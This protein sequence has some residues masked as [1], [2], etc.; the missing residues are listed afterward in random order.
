MINGKHSGSPESGRRRVM[1]P[2]AMV[3]SVCLMAL[4][5][6]A[7]AACGGSSSASG[8]AS[9]SSA[10][11]TAAGGATGAGRFTALRSC[12]EKQGIKLPAPRAGRPPSGGFGAG[13]RYGRP[14]GGFHPPAGSSRTKLAEAI[15]KCGGSAFNRAR[16]GGAAKAALE[17]Y[18]ACMRENGVNL[19]APNT[20]GNGPVF[21]T[22]GID[23]SSAAF[24]TAEGKCRSDLP[25]LFAHG[26][27]PSGAAA[28]GPSGA[29]AP[30]SG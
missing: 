1:R 25:G 12:L 8:A 7:L 17:K 14:A 15:K 6:V 16:F 19:P 29:G 20:S 2:R 3:A 11:S 4:A 9:T 21:N 23:T 27:P 26:A 24:K 28:G 30:S 5:S 18:A 13:G 10:T 22:K